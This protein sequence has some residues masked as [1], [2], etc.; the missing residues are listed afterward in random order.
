MKIS[1]PKYSRAI[2]TPTAMTRND[3][4]YAVPA[5]G[6]DDLAKF[7]PPQGAANQCEIRLRRSLSHTLEA[8]LR[9]RFVNA[10]LS[11]GGNVLRSG[12]LQDFFRT[13]GGV[14]VVGVN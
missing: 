10:G 13:L 14:G 2:V 8:V 3:L 1:R 11:G 7:R 12:S 5:V 9:R 4:G 6:F